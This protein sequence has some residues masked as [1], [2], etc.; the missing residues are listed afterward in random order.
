MNSPG[1]DGVV[2]EEGAH[3]RFRLNGGGRHRVRPRL[4]R[5][6]DAPE[7]D[8]G[9]VFPATG[10]PDEQLDD[11]PRQSTGRCVQS[12]LRG[13]GRHPVVLERMFLTPERD[14][15]SEALDVRLH[16]HA[17]VEEVLKPPARDGK[18]VIRHRDGVNDG[19]SD[20]TRSP[21]QQGESRRRHANGRLGR[22]PASP[23]DSRRGA[24]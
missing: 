19:R 24:R 16:P 10:V 6:A 18:R 12:A 1:Q 3:G 4:E 9:R 23:V 11:R 2:D 17:R 21:L 5:P 13:V 14:L 15:S 22:P 8:D 20:T 7:G